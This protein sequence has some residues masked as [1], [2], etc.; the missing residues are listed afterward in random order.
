MVVDADE[1]RRIAGSLTN[2]IRQSMS[3]DSAL[4]G[5]QR[6]GVVLAQRIAV[7]IEKTDGVKLPVGIV[8]I[9]L[10]RDDLS[11]T[12][13]H[14]ILHSTEFPFDVDGRGIFLIDDVLFTGRTVRAA[15]SAILDFGRP[16]VVRL[17]VFVDRGCRELPIQPDFVG[18]RLKTDKDDKVEVR[19][20]ELDGEDSVRLI[21]GGMEA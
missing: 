9:T 19:V 12:P 3:G 13:P 21:R 1:F 14:P 2:A 17:A 15:L 6:R 11:T 20:K 5:V 7:E 10:Y 8:D 18:I 16:S 4:V